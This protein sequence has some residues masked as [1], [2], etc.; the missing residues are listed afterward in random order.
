MV[1]SVKA[2]ALNGS[3]SRQRRTKMSEEII[4]L[5]IALLS[6]S[7]GGIVGYLLCALLAANDPKGEE[8][9]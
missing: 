5:L 1:E 3:G 9:C 8:K 2:F 4:R 7:A 6:F